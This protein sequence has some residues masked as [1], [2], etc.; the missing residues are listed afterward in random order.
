MHAAIKHTLARLHKE[1]NS[2]GLTLIKGLTKGLFRPL[3]PQDMQDA[4]IS[5]SKREGEHLYRH[6]VEHQHQYMVEFGTSFGIST[7]YLAAAAK[8]NGGRVITT[9]L[10]AHKCMVAQANF[11]QAEVADLIDLRQ[12]DAIETLKQLDSGVD[13]LL[14]DGWNDLYLPVTQLVAPKM[15][16]GALIYVDNANFRS[17]APFIRYMEQSHD[18]RRLNKIGFSSRTAWFEKLK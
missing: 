7:L 18:Y 11:Q 3:K 5:I 10:L 2:Q 8:E 1:A 9:E 12:G 6:L 4:Y 14:L 13:F 16:K 15:N 17:T